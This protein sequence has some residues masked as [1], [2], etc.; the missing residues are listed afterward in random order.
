MMNKYIGFWVLFALMLCTPLL[1]WAETGSTPT[2]TGHGYEFAGNGKRSFDCLNSLYTPQQLPD[3]ALDISAQQ[4][5]LKRALQQQRPVLANAKNWQ[6][7]QI[8]LSPT[9]LRQIAD[10]IAALPGKLQLAQL[11]QHLHPYLLKGEDGCGNTQFTAYF[12][13]LIKVKAKPDSQYKYPIFRKPAA[14]PAG[15]IPTRAEIDSQGALKGLGLEIGYAESLLD[16]YFLQVQGSGLAHFVDTGEKLTFQFGGQNGLPYSS[17][18]RFLVEQGHVPADKISLNAIRDFFSQRPEL[19]P[20]YLA[21]NQ[22]YTFFD[23]VK[24]GPKGTLS[25]EVVP[26]VSIAVDP[27]IIPLGAVLLAEI[28][29]LNDQG[30]FV[31]HAYRL[32]VAQDTGGAIKGPGHVDLFMGAGPE[33]QAKASNLHHYGRLWLLLPRK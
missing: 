3:Q 30:E 6:S 2:V 8:N 21:R 11:T 13:P 18:G 24:T 29:L 9:Q 27:S 19:M 14:W 15:H 26:E 10:R 7:G 23:K 17:L 1:S 28:P 32:L 22:S 12:A 25:T 20:D 33:A 5:A 31:G 16:I 4:S